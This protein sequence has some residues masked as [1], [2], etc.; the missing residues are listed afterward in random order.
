MENWYENWR[1]Q[2]GSCCCRPGLDWLFLFLEPGRSIATPLSS[3]LFDP[4]FKPFMRH[5]LP[6]IL[7]TS[8]NLDF[9]LILFP[10]CFYLNLFLHYVGQNWFILLFI[11]TFLKFLLR[12][13]Y[14]FF[15]LIRFYCYFNKRLKFNI[16]KVE[17]LL[18]WTIYLK[19]Q[20]GV[21]GI[22]SLI[23]VQKSFLTSYIVFLHLMKILLIWKRNWCETVTHFCW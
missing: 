5:G 22:C 18:A 21:R 9:N 14:F 6:K 23:M 7:T 20:I 12:N 10:H 19:E 8:A 11:F 3:Y 13:S 16:L 1:K 17:I 4:F 15:N 2:G